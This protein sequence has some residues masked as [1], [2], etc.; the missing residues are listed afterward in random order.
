MFWSENI[1]ISFQKS[2]SSSDTDMPPAIKPNVFYNK[3]KIISKRRGDT[4]AMKAARQRDTVPVER[5][6][7]KRVTRGAPKLKQD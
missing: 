5:T 2:S 6:P 3:G 1:S 4:L 7:P